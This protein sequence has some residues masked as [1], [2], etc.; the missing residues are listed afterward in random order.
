MGHQMKNLKKLFVDFYQ[1]VKNEEDKELIDF[2]FAVSRGTTSETNIKLRYNV[3]LKRF[4]KQY[5][6]LRLDENRLFSH[7]QKLEI[8]HRD[9]EK[10]QV[11][12][13]HLVFGNPETQ[14]HHKDPFIEGGETIVEKGL[15]ACRYC[16][17]QVV[18]V[19]I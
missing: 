12:G 2:K 9:K 7:D 19:T 17:H 3:M 5:N 14:Y 4:L 15:L 1:S 18:F 6:P 8:F 11:C 13:K 10:C 16:Q